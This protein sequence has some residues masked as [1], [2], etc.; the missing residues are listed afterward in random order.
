M[1]AIH[2]LSEDRG[3]TVL[4]QDGIEEIVARHFAPWGEI[5]RTRV[6]TGRGVA[7]VTC[8]LFQSSYRVP[9]LI[10]HRCERGQCPICKWD[11]M[12]TGRLT[13][14]IYRPRKL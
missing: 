5:A 12:R 7:F 11:A 10:S 8:E 14:T 9:M 4:L 2:P 1:L 3:L 6:L 13:N